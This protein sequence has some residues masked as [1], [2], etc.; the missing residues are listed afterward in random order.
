M[1]QPNDA[2]MSVRA[3][4]GVLA[5]LRDDET[6][7]VTNQG[8]ARVW[9]LIA[10]HA[11]DFHYNPSTMGGA[12]P[13]ALGLALAKPSLQVIAIS[14]DGALTMNL[15]SLISVVASGAD[16]LT[17]VVLDNGIYEVTGGQKT[18]ASIARVDYVTLARSTG[19]RSTSGFCDE[20]SWRAHAPTAMAAQGPRFVSLRVHLALPFDMS[21]TSTQ[22]T[23]Q[24]QRLS[25]GIK[26]LRSGNS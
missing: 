1:K 18:A 2:R 25:Q 3:A 8:S 10:E 12:I 17:V 22:I 24:L 4:L 19:F 11:L 9:P 23:D 14:G 21:T 13:F 16:N 5:D 15:G 7:V 20:A 6:V 26:N